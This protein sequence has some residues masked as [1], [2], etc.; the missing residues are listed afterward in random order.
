MTERKGEYGA[1]AGEYDEL[2]E[3][4][5]NIAMVI[6]NSRHRK[7]CED[8]AAAIEAL[9]A[10]VAGVTQLVKDGAQIERDL[11]AR[12]VQL[13]AALRDFMEYADVDA[14]PLWVRENA[15]ATLSAPAAKGGDND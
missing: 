5:R 2:L 14:T 11:S 12:V 1:L 3:G 6:K 7:A 15:R 13:E 9:M 8:A 10:R 4:L